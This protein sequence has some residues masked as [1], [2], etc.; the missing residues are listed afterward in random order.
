MKCLPCAKQHY[1][2]VKGSVTSVANWVSGFA[3][4]RGVDKFL[5]VSRAV[6][7]LNRLGAA[8]VPYEVIPNFVPDSIGSVA[9]APDP[10]LAELP[11]EPYLLFVGDLN[12][13]KGLPVLIAAYARLGDAPPLVLI[14][15]EFPDTPKDLPPNVFRFASWPHA[16][17]MQA[18]RRCLFGVAPSVWPEPCATVVMEGMAVG[19]PMIVTDV[20]G[21]PDMV[22]HG[23]NGL[24]VPPGD[25]EALTRAMRRLIDEPEARRRM[26]AASLEKVE[27]FKAGAVVS[28]VEAAYRQVGA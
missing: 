15:R 25:V 26:A 10:R 9:A 28:R 20:G 8:G 12:H 27:A 19:K 16:A 11:S 22:D 21:M 7:D 18:W 4:R 14:G 5:A 2:T 1:G 6:A 17:V 24:L 3:V 23:R 13:Q